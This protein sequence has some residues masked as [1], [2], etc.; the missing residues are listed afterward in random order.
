MHH[1]HVIPS[2]IDIEFAPSLVTGGCSSSTG[3]KEDSVDLLS[4]EEI[5][6]RRD[7]QETGKDVRQDGEVQLGV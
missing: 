7:D 3:K 2:H 1:L 4:P 6:D 5:G